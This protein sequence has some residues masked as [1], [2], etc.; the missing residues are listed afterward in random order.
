MLGSR[1][2]KNCSYTLISQ[3]FE[4]STITATEAWIEFGHSSGNFQ[5]FSST[6]EGV[7]NITVS[8]TGIVTASFSNI[9][10]FDCLNYSN[11]VTVSGVLSED[12]LFVTNN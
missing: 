2:A 7:V 3:F 11:I 5:Q 10:A 8:G 1:P 9:Q 12:K 6:D 4:A